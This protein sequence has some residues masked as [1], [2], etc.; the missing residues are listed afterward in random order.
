MLIVANRSFDRYA[1]F[2]PT[3]A[4]EIVGHPGPLAGVAAA[5]AACTT[6]CMLSVPV[7]CPDPP[8]DLVARL[9]A[10]MSDSGVAAVVADDGERR[11][12]LFALYRRELAGSAALAVRA[13]SGVSA[14]QDSLPLLTL[15]FADRRT[16]FVNLNTPAELAAF[17]E[18]RGG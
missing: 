15:G 10:T 5:L 6:P 1:Q 16:H 3:I 9:N 2:A 12:P 11:Q 18:H 17:E 14:W 4:D 8:P 13:A 7:D